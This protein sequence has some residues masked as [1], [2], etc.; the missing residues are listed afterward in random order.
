M[1]ST[2]QSWILCGN[3]QYVIKPDGKRYWRNSRTLREM[4][5]LTQLVETPT[6]P[7]KF[8]PEEG[9]NVWLETQDPIN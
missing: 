8:G 1:T 7:W 5:E 4:N 9:G 3:N 6:I 2:H